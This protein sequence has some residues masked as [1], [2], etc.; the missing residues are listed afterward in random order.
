VHVTEENAGENRI[1]LGSQGQD[2]FVHNGRHSEVYGDSQHFGVST[3]TKIDL[4]GTG[5]IS[6]YGGGVLNFGDE[7]RGVS[8]VSLERDSDRDAYTLTLSDYQS[9]IVVYDNSGGNTIVLS[10]RTQ[11][12]VNFGPV[13]S[14]VRVSAAD[15]GGVKID[16]G[17][18]GIILEIVEESSVVLSSELQNVLVR[19]TK[20]TIIST[21]IAGSQ[22]VD[23][24]IGQSVVEVNGIEQ[25]ILTG[26]GNTIV[27]NASSLMRI[28]G[29]F[30]DWSDN[31]LIN[32]GYD[33]EIVI[34]DMIP[35]AIASYWDIDDLNHAIRIT[36]DGETAVI[37][38]DAWTI[39]CGFSL[40]SDGM[41]GSVLTLGKLSEL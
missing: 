33:D 32:F 16:G 22:V 15:A 26:P 35:V 28:E 7:T 8:E 6:M 36:K 17:E 10:D 5:K 25:K 18:A 29:A 14:Q 24:G 9:G 37:Q 27:D 34:N 13:E 12:V 41:S 1:V 31:R 4:G 11:S 38:F 19:L 20:P 40:K 3:G 21:S 23:A 2:V 39:D 30:E